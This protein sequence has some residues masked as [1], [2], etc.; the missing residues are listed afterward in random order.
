MKKSMKFFRK[1]TPFEW[2]L[3]IVV[4]VLLIWFLVTR[5]NTARYLIFAVLSFYFFIG[6]FLFISRKE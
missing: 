4:L 5:S 6:P 3:L 1:P 2:V